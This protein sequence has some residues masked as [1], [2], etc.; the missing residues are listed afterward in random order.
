MRQKQK[1]STRKPMSTRTRFFVVCSKCF[2]LFHAKAQREQRPQRRMYFSASLRLSLRLCAKSQLPGEQGPQRRMYF[3]ASLRLS[4]RLCAKKLNCL[5]SKGHKEE[6]I[7]LRLCVFLC[8]FARKISIA[9]R[10]RATK[11][12]VF[13]CVFASFFA[14]LRESQL[15][16]EQGP[17]RR[18]NFLCVFA[19][20]FAPLREISIARRA[21][22]GAVACRCARQGRQ[23]FSVLCTHQRRRTVLID[24]I[25]PLKFPELL[26]RLVLAL[27]SRVSKKKL[28]VHAR[29]FIVQLNAT[30]QQ[31]HGFFVSLQLHEQPPEIV[32]RRKT[33]WIELDGPPQQRFGF[34][35]FTTLARDVSET[36]QRIRHIRLQ[37]ERVSKGR[38]RLGILA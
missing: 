36:R 26:V 30:R 34:D 4:L 27:E 31:R 38:H 15:P 5:A 23:R 20:F 14:P 33:F 25:Q 9:W 2:C 37:L 29:I 32:I 28:V 16:G 24:F 11:K 18:I 19:S 7:S 8:A 6:C 35:V 21:W 22:L 13:L 1:M 12:N 10:A 3:F 17:Q